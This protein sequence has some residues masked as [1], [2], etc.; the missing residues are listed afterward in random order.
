MNTNRADLGSLSPRYSAFR[1]THTR[2]ADPIWLL[3]TQ[4]A[5][6]LTLFLPS[7]FEPGVRLM[8]GASTW[9]LWLEGAFSCGCT[10]LDDKGGGLTGQSVGPRMDAST[11]TKVTSTNLMD[12]G[13]FSSRCCTFRRTHTSVDP[14]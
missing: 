2:S 8:V 7:R 13:N 4:L 1:R 11:I 9:T 3:C 5:L 10:F 6:P 14:V 12:S